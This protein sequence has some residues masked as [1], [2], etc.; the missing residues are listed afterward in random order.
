MN[1]D[2]YIDSRRQLYETS[3]LPSFSNALTNSLRD[4]GLNFENED[5]ERLL[6]AITGS[7]VKISHEMIISEIK[8]YHQMLLNHF[9]IQEKK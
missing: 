1:F 7:C 9:E 2:E 3:I 8:A 4:A 5:M 6:G